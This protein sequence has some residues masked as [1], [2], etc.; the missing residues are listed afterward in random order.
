V[1][2]SCNKFA[3]PIARGKLVYNVANVTF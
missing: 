3:V 1:V 2:E